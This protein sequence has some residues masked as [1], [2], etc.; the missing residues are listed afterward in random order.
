MNI[1]HTCSVKIFFLKPK[2]LLQIISNNI[3][4]WY[5]YLHEWLILMVNVGKNTSPMDGIGFGKWIMT[6][7]QL[8]TFF[9]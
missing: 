3:N 9:H 4:V 7:K 5:I 6:P 8:P 2:E 1:F